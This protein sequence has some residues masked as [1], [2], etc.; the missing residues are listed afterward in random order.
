MAL[1]AIHLFAIGGHVILY[2]YTVYQTDQLFNDQ[3]NRGKYNLND[4][5]E[6][7]VPVKTQ[8]LQNWNNFENI[9]GQVQFKNTCY[10]YVKL[11]L[12]RDNIYLMCIP[13]Y[14][15]TR[16][17]SEN[18][19]NARETGDIPLNKKDHVPFGKAPVMDK[20]SC[21]VTLY[22]FL[23]SVT[24]L[25]INNSRLYISSVKRCTEVPEQPPKCFI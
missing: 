20:Y 8:C 15:K 12:S 24:I 3:I 9:H 6:I 17:I 10:N 7:K 23:S 16:L 14:E 21:S 19:I 25:N 2:Q 1:L 22:H 5:V 18:I 11:K 13:N 4:L